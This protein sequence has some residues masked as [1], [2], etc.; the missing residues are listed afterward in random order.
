MENRLSKLESTPLKRLVR[1]KINE[2]QDTHAPLPPRPPTLPPRPPNPSAP[3]IGLNSVWRQYSE[4]L[5]LF[6]FWAEMAL[7][8]RP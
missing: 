7:A 5:A 4:P 8:I 6:V 2:R 3:P 1:L